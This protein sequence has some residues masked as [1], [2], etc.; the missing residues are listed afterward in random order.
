MKWDDIEAVWVFQGKKRAELLG[1]L[2]N[3]FSAPALDLM[4]DVADDE[5]DNNENPTF[6][7]VW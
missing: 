2:A 1:Y 7:I 4:G 3:M 5:E 6:E